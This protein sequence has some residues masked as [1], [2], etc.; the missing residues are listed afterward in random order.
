MSS[1]WDC[2]CPRCPQHRALACVL[3]SLCVVRQVGTPRPIAFVVKVLL[4]VGSGLLAARNNRVVHMDVKAANV[5]L[6]WE[7]PDS[8]YATNRQHQPA[9]S[10]PI[11]CCSPTLTFYSVQ[12]SGPWAMYLSS[13]C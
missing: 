5:V 11:H 9:P 13:C 10:I 3:H 12:D 8:R 4:D 6:D 1:S 7:G 2:T